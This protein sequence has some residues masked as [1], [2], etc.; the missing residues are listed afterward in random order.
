M[1]CHEGIPVRGK[2]FT[3]LPALVRSRTAATCAGAG[4]ILFWTSLGFA[5]KYELVQEGQE[6]LICYGDHE[7]TVWLACQAEIA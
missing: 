4:S 7:I 1:V 3:D 6:F 5:V 2:G